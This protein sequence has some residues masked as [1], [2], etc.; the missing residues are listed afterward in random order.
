VQIPDA[1]VIDDDD[2]DD[3]DDGDD[4]VQFRIK[5]TNCTPA[6]WQFEQAYRAGAREAG[7][8][9]LFMTA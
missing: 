3:D 4:G 2:D 9:N 5:H 1:A 7:I 8:R 6:I